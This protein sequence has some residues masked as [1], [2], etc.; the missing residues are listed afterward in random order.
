MV[1][2]EGAVLGPLTITL[3]PVA[4]G[5]TPTL[6]LVG[7]GVSLSADPDGLRVERMFPSSG[8]AAAGVVVG[9]HIIAVEGTGVDS[10]GLDGAIAR[11][12]GAPGTF[13][14]LTLRRDD[15]DL[16]LSVERKPLENR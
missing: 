11:I 14:R 10:L 2:T 15:K 3:R 12:R 4:P 1:A 16:E 5:E 6:E 13:V 9:D 8:A 7:I